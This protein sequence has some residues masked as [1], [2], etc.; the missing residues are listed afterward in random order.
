MRTVRR[1]FW[2]LAAKNVAR[3]IIIVASSPMFIPLK[4]T[5]AEYWIYL[6]GQFGG[7]HAFGYNSAES[8]PIW[9]KSGVHCWGWPWQILGAIRS[10]ATV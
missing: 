5:S 4:A 9:M 7:V 6:T 1:R 2:F 10:V 8:G 3:R